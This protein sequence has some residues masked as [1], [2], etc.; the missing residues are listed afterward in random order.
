[1][2]STVDDLNYPEKTDTYYV[3]NAPYVF[4]ACYKVRA[5]GDGFSCS[6][7]FPETEALVRGGSFSVVQFPGCE[8][9]VARKNQK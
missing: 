4:S 9:S 8:A 1:M 2:I 6:L 3:V 7:L 5:I